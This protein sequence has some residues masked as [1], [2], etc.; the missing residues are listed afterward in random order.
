MNLPLED[1][2]TKALASWLRNRGY[3]W[4]HH[5]PNEAKRSPR[6]G[7]KLKDMGMSPGFPDLIIFE[8]PEGANFYGVAIEMKRRNGGR[9]SKYQAAWLA[10]MSEVGWCT[11]VCKGAQ[12]AMEY[13]K[14]LGY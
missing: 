4:F 2:E 7:K 14:C 10:Y 9:V 8:V 1:Q 5:S 6:L 13:L 12:D 11:K 3:E